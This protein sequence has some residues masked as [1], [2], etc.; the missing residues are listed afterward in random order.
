MTRGTSV[1]A[2]GMHVVDRCLIVSVNREPGDD[3]L[4]ALRRK[5]LGSIEGRAG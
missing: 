1:A 5:I 4:R 3:E 2:D